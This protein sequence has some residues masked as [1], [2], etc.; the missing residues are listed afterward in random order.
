MT[1]KLSDTDKIEVEAGDL[2]F[3]MRVMNE[4]EANQMIKDEEDK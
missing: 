3:L 4:K 1:Y 2:R